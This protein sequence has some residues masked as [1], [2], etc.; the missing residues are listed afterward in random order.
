MTLATA[1]TFPSSA[2]V[3]PSELLGF[4]VLGLRVLGF[5]V[6]GVPRYL[7]EEFSVSIGLEN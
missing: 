7:V 4:G 1:S 5:R 2:M 6:W 3:A